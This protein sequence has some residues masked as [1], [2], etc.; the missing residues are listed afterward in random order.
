MIRARQGIALH[1]ER[2]Q[3]IDV[4]QRR[5]SIHL[6]LNGAHALRLEIGGSDRLLDRNQATLLA[7]AL[8]EL[9][10]RQVLALSAVLFPPLRSEDDAAWLREKVAR[11]G[12][13]MEFEDRRPEG[14][15]IRPA[16]RRLED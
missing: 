4:R 5:A 14:S 10:D 6:A 16:T 3:P 11:F 7:A 9:S 1:R 13:E 2:L 12:E 15:R 8:A